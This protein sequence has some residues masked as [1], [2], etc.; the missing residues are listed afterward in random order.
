MPN[1]SDST[2]HARKERVLA[3][4]RQAEGIK[5]SEIAEQFHNVNRKTVNSYLRELSDKGFLYKEGLYWYYNEGYR[6]I[7]LRKLELKAEEAMTL[8]LATRLL[9]KHTDR[10]NEIAETV[11]M[12]IA[13]VLHDDAG[14]HESI[15]LS[16]QELLQRPEEENFQD[17]YRLVMY[18]TLY[19]VAL[20]INYQ[21]YRRTPFKTIIHPYLIEPSGIGYATYVIGYNVEMDTLR[22]YKLERIRH[23]Q[24]L[25]GQRFEIPTDFPGLDILK[26]AWSIFHGDETINVTLRF[27][28]DV[29]QRVRETNWHHS[30]EL[31]ENKRY[32][33]MKLQVAD[34]TDLIP[35]IR[36][37]GANCEVLEPTELREEMEGE[38][39]ALAKLYG[40]ES[41]SDNAFD[42]IF[43]D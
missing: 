15:L 37:W 12:Q 35:W 10:R 14:V 16:V 41:H 8:Y 39:R 32:V 33:I 7:I 30:I 42:D 9:V 27:H 1:I 29:V 34:T 6:P 38:A 2:R 36:G 18:A 19:K 40:I 4:V 17:V 26:N 28:P 22:T 11:L 23:A 20:E 43:G 25:S 3:I 21:P 5:E 31:T 13:S 24:V